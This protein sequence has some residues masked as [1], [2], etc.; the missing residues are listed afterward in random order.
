ML[1]DTELGTK[2]S[3]GGVLDSS[4]DLGEVK[5]SYLIRLLKL[6]WLWNTALFVKCW[7]FFEWKLESQTSQLTWKWIWKNIFIENFVFCPMQ[8][9]VFFRMK[10][11]TANITVNMHKWFR[12]YPSNLFILSD[13]A[14][15]VLSNEE[16][17]YKHR[18]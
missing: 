7:Y 13:G 2:V 11:E 10:S 1:V 12:F 9:W 14:L 4:S 5:E 6:K 3:F 8:L 18:N 17:N 15:H 16:W